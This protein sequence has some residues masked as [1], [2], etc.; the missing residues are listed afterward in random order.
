M[1]ESLSISPTYFK[2]IFLR[3]SVFKSSLPDMLKVYYGNNFSTLNEIYPFF[4]LPLLRRV[5]VILFRREFK[6]SASR[7]PSDRTARF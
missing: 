6:F 1:R 3:V 4:I 7:S 5:L 2:N